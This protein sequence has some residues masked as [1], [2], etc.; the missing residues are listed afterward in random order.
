M[1]VVSYCFY[2]LQDTFIL[3]FINREPKKLHIIKLDDLLPDAVLVFRI[4]TCMNGPIYL[5]YQSFFMAIEIY[6]AGTEG[7][8]AAKF[9]A[10]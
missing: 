4:I 10:G 5:D 9:Q 8:L 7:M 6:Y 2:V 1:K 3:N